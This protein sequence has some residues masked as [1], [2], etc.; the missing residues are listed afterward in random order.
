MQ[1][2]LKGENTLGRHPDNSIQILDRIASK[3]HCTIHYK[4]DNYVL[5]DL[6]SLNGTLVNGQK[7]KDRVLFDGD[8][9]SL[10][11]T[12]IKVMLE[13]K[14]EVSP[15]SVLPEPEEGRLSLLQTT[16]K[17]NEP[18]LNQPQLSE[19][20]LSAPQTFGVPVRKSPS[21]GAGFK[22]AEITGKIPMPKLSQPLGQNPRK[23]SKQGDIF[24]GEENE[25][26][27]AKMVGINVDMESGRT[28]K[29]AVPVGAKPPSTHVP[30]F[31]V[32]PVVKSVDAQNRLQVPFNNGSGVNN[33][34]SLSQASP[35]AS[36]SKSNLSRVT[37]MGNGVES[38]LR[39]K[40]VAQVPNFLPE[41]QITD[42]A[43]LRVDYEKLRIGYELNRAMGVELDVQKTGEKILEV[44][45]QLLPAD[46][47]II[48]L[49]NESKELVPQAM[50][51]KNNKQEDVVIS[52]TLV[53]EVMKE[54]AGVLSN[55][56][57][58][59]SRFS[60]ARSIIMQGI[61]SSMAVPMLHGGEV[62]GIMVID[63]QVASHAF[64]ERDLQLFQ[65]IAN[66]A[67]VAVQN[68]MFA[69]KL[70]QEAVTRARFQRLLSPQIAQQVIEGKVDIS[71]GGVH[72]Q[73]TVLFSD[74]RG[75]T[76][77]SEKRPPQ[78]IVDMLNEYFER[79]VDVIFKHEGTLDKFIGDAIMAIFG[80]PVAHE[81]DPLRAVVSA[82]E[83]MQSLETYNQ[84]RA[85]QQESPIQIGI[86]I[87]TGDLVAGYLGSSQA[88][89]YTVIGDTVNTASRLCSAAKSGEIIISHDTYLKV[90]HRV[91][92][93]T[94]DPVSLKGKAEPLQVYKVT[95]L[96]SL[97]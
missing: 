22:K 73:G 6:G 4:A 17:L 71:K 51:T 53:E 63:S 48:L 14:L 3:M 39:S 57:S 65:T 7:V 37:I 58:V 75:F 78:A 21:L 86:G 44:A 66:Q 18:Q 94:M 40:V 72:C 82:V 41:A 59:D 81:D 97:A 87:N 27:T 35:K 56:A 15:A 8:V 1:A 62:L 31:S 77:M 84:W 93:H 49:L 79:M 19:P 50:R 67:A 52:K 85:S 74:I 45:F 69:Q 12:K 20:Q 34:P 68:S 24:P 61:R 26:V 92:V 33:N 10:G 38:H 54:K 46:R 91:R 25:K 90:G 23:D 9:I 60:A 76:S 80:A 16:P 47:G 36:E 29:A 2:E 43:Q 55:D 95:G 28:V 83:M 30:V 13:Q 11:N 42:L 5:S 32:P 96:N 70:E 88:L 64:T 89:A